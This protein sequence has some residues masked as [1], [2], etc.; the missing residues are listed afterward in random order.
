LR[1]DEF[2]PWGGQFDAVSLRNQFE[3][4][5]SA[6]HS[7]FTGQQSE[8]KGAASRADDQGHR[9]QQPFQPTVENE[10]FFDRPQTAA[11]TPAESRAVRGYAR[12][13]G[14]VHSDF[15]HRL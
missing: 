10:P 3:G 15:V 8:R 1:E 12:P 13:A 9:H 11:K 6:K 7:H 14:R 5:S 4:W 2:L